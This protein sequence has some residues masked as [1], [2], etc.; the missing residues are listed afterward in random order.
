MADVSEDLVFTDEIPWIS[1]TATLEGFGCGEDRVY[2][3]EA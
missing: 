2:C 1:I 3:E